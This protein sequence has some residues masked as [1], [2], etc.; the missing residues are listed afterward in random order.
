MWQSAPTTTLTWLTANSATGSTVTPVKWSQRVPNMNHK[1]ILSAESYQQNKKISLLAARVETIY[2]PPCYESA[3]RIQRLRRSAA[4]HN[5]V[6]LSKHDFFG[7]APSAWRQRRHCLAK[8]CRGRGYLGSPR[9]R[10]VHPLHDRLQ[11]FPYLLRHC[12]FPHIVKRRRHRAWATSPRWRQPTFKIKVCTRRKRVSRVSPPIA[13]LTDWHPVRCYSA[14]PSCRPVSL[15]PVLLLKPRE[16][17][18]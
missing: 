3:T 9:R 2:Q 11:R 18:L 4:L 6:V 14:L 17:F 16:I 12:Y 13:R 1:I 5:A 10:L 15:C 8:V 7:G